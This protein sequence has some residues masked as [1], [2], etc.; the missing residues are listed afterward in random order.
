MGIKIITDNRSARHNFFIIE[1][2]ETGV[3]LKGSEVKSIRRGKVNLKEAF[4]RVDNGELYLFQCH[5]SP[6]EEAG[7][8][9]PDPVRPRKLLAHKREILKFSGR[10]QQQGLTLVPTKM[11]LKNGRVKVEVALAKGKQLHDK[12]QSLKEKTAMREAQQALKNRQ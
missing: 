10:A 1:T 5:I 11:Y 6:Y 7:K 9:A 2:L 3:V 8:S 12:R 4:C